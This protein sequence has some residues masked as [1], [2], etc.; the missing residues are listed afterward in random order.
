MFY[1]VVMITKNVKTILFASLIT[2]MILP[3]SAMEFAQAVTNEN[4][5]DKAKKTH[6]EMV[7]EGKIVLPGGHYVD[8][9]TYKFVDENKSIEENGKNGI[10]T[11][12]L[13]EHD[14]KTII[15]VDKALEKIAKDKKEKGDTS[16]NYPAD[17]YNTIA[18]KE[19]IDSMSY[20]R[21][22]WKVPISP[23][24]YDG[25]DTI[26][27]FNA[28][29]PHASQAAI[30]QPVLQFGNNGPCTGIGSSWVFYPYVYV[31]PTVNTKGSC[32]AVQPGDILRGTISKSGSIWTISTYNY[33]TG[34]SGSVQA[35]YAGLADWSL[36][37]L[38]TYGLATNC[39]SIPGDERF[40]SMT[41]TGDSSSWA[42]VSNPNLQ[43]CGMDA[44]IV[45]DSTVDLL[46]NN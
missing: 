22:F 4:A 27:T 40:Y 3:F 17:G 31:S 18:L 11:S 1:K 29:Q 44:S 26:F 36:V 42:D 45:S 2:A 12:V 41:I 16:I 37:A 13:K 35:S 46:N 32:L 5:N 19:D 30:F 21:A 10:D 24:Y 9:T 6:E 39:S 7:K 20:F 34:L 25:S 43:W 23:T 28:M 38:E 33:R 15:D 8:K 14:G